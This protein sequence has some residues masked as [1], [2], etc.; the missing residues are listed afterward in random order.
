MADLDTLVDDLRAEGDDLDALV[1]EL[2][3]ERWS[4]PT[5]AEGWTVA[6]QIG[7]LSWT[8]HVAER[9]TSGASGDTEAKEEFALTLKKAWE[10]PGGFVDEAAEAQS[11]DPDLLSTWRTR[12]HAMTDALVRVPP[13][14]KIDWFG[15]PMSAASMAT[16]RL[17]ETWAHGQDVADALG[18]TRVATDR[19]RGVA[20]IGVRTRDFAY[21]VNQQA[22][23][24]EQFR[25]ELTAPSGELWTWGPEGT[26]QRV[27][28]PA[29]DFCL[30]VT[31]RAHRENLDIRAEGA[32]A[33]HWLTIAQAFAGPPG[34][35]REKAGREKA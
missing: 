30:L 15:P 3:P 13:G 12:R 9:T 27:S 10:N 16:A 4:A 35:G 22:P 23:P 11:R 8:D 17:M 5:P 2:T 29:L 19:I 31:Q 14:T 1:A 18:V 20:H 33:A 21:A 28:G 6:H 25:V 32:D 24:S 26:A 34:Q 7:H